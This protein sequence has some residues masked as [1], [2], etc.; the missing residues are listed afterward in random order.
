ME[1]LVPFHL[2]DVRLRAAKI[3]PKILAAR[4]KVWMSGRGH[5]DLSILLSPLEKWVD[6]RAMP[7]AKTIIEFV[8]LAQTFLCCSNNLKFCHR[9]MY[10]AILIQ[11]E[12]YHNLPGASP[13]CAARKYSRYIRTPLSWYRAVALYPP[14]RE[15]VIAN[16]TEME[17]STIRS[18]T[19]FI[20]RDDRSAAAASSAVVP[21]SSLNRS[22]SRKSLASSFGG[23]S[24]GDSNGETDAALEELGSL[25][26]VFS[27]SPSHQ[28]LALVDSSPVVSSL[29]D[30][31]CS[32]VA[33]FEELQSLAEASNEQLVVVGGA[34]QAGAHLDSL[35]AELGDCG[36]AADEVTP[37]CGKVGALQRHMTSNSKRLTTE[38]AAIE[39]VKS[40][41]KKGSQKDTG[42]QKGSPKKDS[43][44]KGSPKKDSLKKGSP[45]KAAKP[46]TPAQIAAYALKN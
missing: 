9:D 15:L 10:D 12:S 22:C 43:P 35:F 46:K 19:D 39:K 14:K 13:C 26:G 29:G 31:K 11:H 42:S 40:R 27:R 23:S 7:P 36:E 6:S 41:N 8:D 17:F 3:C 38:H 34:E 20:S 30:S 37:L 4:L 33:A 24:V 2:S 45:E 25:G 21:H 32:M 5:S 1:A 28:K 16:C 44:K 18:V